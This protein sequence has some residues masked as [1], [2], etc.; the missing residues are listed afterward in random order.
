[1]QTFFTES[2]ITAINRV[3]IASPG[4]VC[5]RTLNEKSLLIFPWLPVS[6]TSIEKESKMFHSEERHWI[7]RCFRQELRVGDG[8]EV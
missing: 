7:I 3:A 2:E 8:R 6:V 4:W 1:M 5:K